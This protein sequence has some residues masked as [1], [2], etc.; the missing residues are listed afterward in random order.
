MYCGEKSSGRKLQATSPVAMMPMAVMPVTMM[1]PVMVPA[2]V[3]ATMMPV[4]VV[5]ADLYGLDLVDFILRHNGRFKICR[6]HGHRVD[7][8]RRNRSGLRRFPKRGCPK[9]Q[10]RS[11]TQKD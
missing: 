4:M 3:P 5:P 6:R 9:H 8:N 1:P 10:A 7:R 2:T 11:K